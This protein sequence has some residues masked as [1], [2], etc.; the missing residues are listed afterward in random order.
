MITERR[1]EAPFRNMNEMIRNA[2]ELGRKCSGAVVRM[3]S[4]KMNA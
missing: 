2:K 4:N 1:G 3:Y